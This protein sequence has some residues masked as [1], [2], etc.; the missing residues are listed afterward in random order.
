MDR[1][2]PFIVY[3]VIGGSLGFFVGGIFG[4]A[5]SFLGAVVGMMVGGFVGE[6]R[7][8]LYQRVENLE[9]QLDEP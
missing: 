2:L 3:V 4:F 5:G 1:I 7:A 8:R 9:R 6:S